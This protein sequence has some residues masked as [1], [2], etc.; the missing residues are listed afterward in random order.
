VKREE[1]R[2]VLERWLPYKP[3]T[4]RPRETPM[5]ADESDPRALTEGPLDERVLNQIRAL[6]GPGESGLLKKVAD[7]YLSNTP[8]LLERLRDA[9]AANDPEAMYKAAH[10]L[11]SSS[12]NLGA[13]S[14][15]EVAKD[16]ELRGRRRSLEGAI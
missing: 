4:S 2:L 12:A 10:A 13:R 14:L 3:P 15:A 8:S 6:Q 5:E 7:L 9:V 1:L 11:K 16:L